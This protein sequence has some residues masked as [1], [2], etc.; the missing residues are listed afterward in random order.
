M[1]RGNVRP[2]QRETKAA[3]GTGFR[4]VLGCTNNS[5][6]ISEGNDVYPTLKKRLYAVKGITE[7]VPSLAATFCP[8]GMR[9]HEE[10]GCGTRIRF[11]GQM[12]EQRSPGG[13]GRRPA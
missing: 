12:T 10:R 11:T 2:H 13:C 3:G 5:I 7:Q 8:A 9:N 6:I 1:T 4:I